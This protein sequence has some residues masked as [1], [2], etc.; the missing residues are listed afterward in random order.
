[1]VTK[2]I[3]MPTCW[4]WNC[5]RRRRW[6]RFGS[7][8]AV[9]PI[10][11]RFSRSDTE[12]EA[13]NSEDCHLHASSG[14]HEQWECIGTESYNYMCLISRW[15]LPTCASR[16]GIGADSYR[17][18]TVMYMYMYVLHIA[19]DRNLQ[20]QGELLESRNDT[21]KT[22]TFHKLTGDVIRDR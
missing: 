22:T 11:S 7:G 14:I 20:T 18:Y 4:E 6:L 10:E 16:L 3:M 5:H 13:S 19:L 21:L 12:C 15:S 2:I 8:S 9:W 17:F 1:M